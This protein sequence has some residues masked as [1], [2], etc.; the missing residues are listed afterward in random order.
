MILNCCECQWYCYLVKYYQ[1]LQSVHVRMSRR[2][3]ILNSVLIKQTIQVLVVFL[4]KL[5]FNTNI[6]SSYSIWTCSTLDYICNW[7]QMV[8]DWCRVQFCK[9]LYK[10]NLCMS[11]ITVGVYI[12]HIT[13]FIRIQDSPAYKATPLHNYQ[14]SGKYQYSH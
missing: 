1:I 14:F 13:V 2:Q 9:P 11:E 7:Q 4:W 8:R 10:Q 12:C 3:F 5:V 6:C